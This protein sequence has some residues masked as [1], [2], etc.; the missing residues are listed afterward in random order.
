MKRDRGGMHYSSKKVEEDEEIEAP[1]LAGGFTLPVNNLPKISFQ[2]TGPSFSG[3]SSTPYTFSSPI[4]QTGSTMSASS[5]VS[6]GVN[7]TV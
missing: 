6:P 4:S 5:P 7:V 2:P 3:Q 1:D